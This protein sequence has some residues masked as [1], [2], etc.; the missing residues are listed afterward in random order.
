MTNI[1]EIIGAMHWDE[2]G[3]KRILKLYSEALQDGSIPSRKLM[4]ALDAVNATEEQTEQ[5]CDFFEKNGIEIDGSDALDILSAQQDEQDPSAEDLAE[6]EQDEQEEANEEAQKETGDDTVTDDNVR[7]YL[8]EI[9]KIEML[10]PEEEVSIAKQ[11]AEGD[12]DAKKRMVEANLRL[13]V[14]VVKRYLG[15]GLTMLDLVQEGNIGLI[16]AVDKFDYTRG[17]KFS[18]YATWWI[19]QAIT[20]AIA[21]QGRTIRVPVHVVETLNRIS[22]VKRL[23][24]QE[25]GRDPT[26]QEIADRLGMKP[27]KVEEVQTLTREPVTINGPTNSEEGGKLEDFIPNDAVVQPEDEIARMMLREHIDTV[28]KRLT[29]REERVLRLRYGLEGE[30]PYTLEEVGQLLNVTRE[31]VRQIEHKALRKLHSP[32]NRRPLEGF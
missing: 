19:R 3:K 15:R 16:K 28:L 23:L 5:I 18:T 12:A 21:D 9:G 20:R 7:M 27:E 2:A 10:T 4:E 14:S 29:P 32:A 6:I 22:R 30:K 25:L 1:P 13:V 11:I 8:R 26:T 31:R 24:A 17:Y